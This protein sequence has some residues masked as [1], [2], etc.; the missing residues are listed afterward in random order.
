MNF[1]IYLV[2]VGLGKGLLIVVIIIII[3]ICGSVLLFED[4]CL[5]VLGFKWVLKMLFLF[6]AL[7]LL[8]RVV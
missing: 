8:V 6:V 3:G 4:G 2:L 5:K 1:L 7:Y